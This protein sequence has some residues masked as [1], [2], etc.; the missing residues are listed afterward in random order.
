MISNPVYHVFPEPN[1][2]KRRKKIY[3]F[4]R[5][6][7][8][9]KQPEA[10]SSYFQGHDISVVRLY[11]VHSGWR[12]NWF[13]FVGQRS[14]IK[15]SEIS[16]NMF[17]DI[18]CDL[19]K[20]YWLNFTHVVNITR[21]IRMN[22]VACARKLGFIIDTENNFLWTPPNIPH[23]VGLEIYQTNR[24]TTHRIRPP[25]HLSLDCNDETVESAKENYRF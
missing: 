18:P 19:L 25:K 9:D 16:W 4:V 21:I 1:K 8:G 22:R 7:C 5:L 2:K 24:N 6:H 23:A 17:E 13:D 15:I 11:S 14:K 12:M 20:Q 10:G 3:W